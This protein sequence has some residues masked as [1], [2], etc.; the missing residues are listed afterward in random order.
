MAPS[1]RSRASKR[2]AKAD[3]NANKRAQTA[4]AEEAANAENASAFVLAKYLA[5]ATKTPESVEIYKELASGDKTKGFIRTVSDAAITDGI[6]DLN[7]CKLLAIDSPEALA[8]LPAAIK[9]NAA[10]NGYCHQVLIGTELLQGEGWLAVASEYAT[11]TLAAHELTASSLDVH[12]DGSGPVFATIHEDAAGEDFDQ[13]AWLT[14][15]AGAH[16]DEL[17]RE[18]LEK[19][20]SA[21][22]EADQQAAKERAEAEA[23]AAARLAKARALMEREGHRQREERERADKIASAQEISDEDAADG[24]DAGGGATGKDGGS[25]GLGSSSAALGHVERESDL[26]KVSFCPAAQA[27]LD[28]YAKITS[29]S[30][31]SP[32]ER[33]STSPSVGSVKN[34]RSRLVLSMKTT[35]DLKA[36]AAMRAAEGEVRTARFVKLPPLVAIKEMTRVM[37]TVINRLLLHSARRPAAV[38]SGEV[39]AQ[40]AILTTALTDMK[41]WYRDADNRKRMLAAAA[42]KDSK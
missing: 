22:R 24:T 2:K 1:K 35:A 12:P 21:R 10:H 8:L 15:L 20:A 30:T 34:D 33:R 16:P 41:G 7:K 6:I 19:E 26:P 37:S 25:S 28:A 31:L 36:A 9:L 29:S 27:Q 13:D 11:R 3:A 5:G 38:F 18:R 42:I 4:T 39:E 40:M 32:A 17:E 14:V 23:A